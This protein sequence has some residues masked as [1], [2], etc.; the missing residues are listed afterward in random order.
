MDST[1]LSAAGCPLQR[2]IR[3]SPCLRLALKS[4]LLERCWPLCWALLTNPLLEALFF[5]WLLSLSANSPTP[6]PAIPLIFTLSNLPPVYPDH[7]HS[8]PLVL[9]SALSLCQRQ[10]SFGVRSRDSGAKSTG[11][12]ICSTAA[13]S[14]A[15][16]EFLYVYFFICEM[17]AMIVPALGH[18]R[19]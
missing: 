16:K 1:S 9:V 15:A 10:A 13:W 12:D 11:S 5:L 17:E 19:D 4:H 2:P 6:T 14:W 18:C 7:W 3:L 8:K